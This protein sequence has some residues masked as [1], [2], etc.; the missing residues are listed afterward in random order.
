MVHFHDRIY[1]D[2]KQFQNNEIME[3]ELRL[4]DEED[5]QTDE[6]KIHKNPGFKKAQKGSKGTRG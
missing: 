2:K 6:R 1:P 3:E 5:E 4:I